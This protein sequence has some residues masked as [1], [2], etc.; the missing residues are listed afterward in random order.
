MP[1]PQDPLKHLRVATPCQVTWKGMTG[2][3]RVRHCS[4]CSLNVYNFAE[5]TRDEVRALLMR[6]EGRVCARLYRRADGMLLTS[7]CPSGLRA[8]RQR[9][10]RLA[11]AV[12][13]ALFSVS[14]FASDGKTCEK[15]RLRKH[16]SK[17]KLQ[18]ERAV[19]PRQAVL[20]GAVR[21][22]GGDP[23]PGVTVVLR[24][25]AAQREITTVT[26]VNGAFTIA[27]LSD[28]I[29]RADV[30]LEGFKSAVIEH[31]PLKQNEVTHV[32]VALRI[33]AFTGTM[34]ILT[35][36]PMMANEPTSTTF[37]QEFIN[38]LPI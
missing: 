37:S 32:R 36:D 15:P 34:G 20:T 23:L 6:T 2:D 16:G 22:E 18:V 9:M 25:E 38:K 24:D 31:L 33:D 17:V 30:K 14:A 28:G 5:L 19:T 35:M 3:E 21:I 27:A 26:D 4:L 1:K 12:I 29:Y 13:A 11:A 10:S 7:D 8:L